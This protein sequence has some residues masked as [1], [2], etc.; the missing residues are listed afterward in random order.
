MKL[1][2]LKYQVIV[3]SEDGWLHCSKKT[4]ELR[5]WSP[6]AIKKYNRIGFL[7]IDAEWQLWNS[8]QLEPQQKLS[9]L[10]CF[11]GSKVP[12]VVH[13]GPIENEPASKFKQVFATAMSCDDDIIAQFESPDEIKKAIERSVTLESIVQQLQKYKCI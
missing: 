4:D 8:T 9:F 7:V 6:F 5:C 1:Q 3:L 13:L 2:E 10:K 12:V 11:F